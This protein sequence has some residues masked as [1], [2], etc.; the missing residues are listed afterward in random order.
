M[1]RIRLKDRVR[2]PDG[3]VTTVS[4]ALAAGTLKKLPIWHAQWNENGSNIIGYR[5]RWKTETTFF[6]QIAA[7]ATYVRTHSQG[8]KRDD[9]CRLVRRITIAL[10]DGSADYGYVSEKI[11]LTDDLDAEIVVYTVP[12]ATSAAP[13]S[14]TEEAA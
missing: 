6:G 14:A 5:P 13:M 11:L 9:R 8:H 10:P 12:L 7:A 3:S 1:L 4:D 2:L